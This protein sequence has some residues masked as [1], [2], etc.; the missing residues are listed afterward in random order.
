VAR[1]GTDAGI[2]PCIY[3]NVRVHR[4]GVSPS[5]NL[6]FESSLLTTGAKATV[7]SGSAKVAPAKLK[8]ILEE[9]EKEGFNHKSLPDFGSKLAAL[10]LNDSVAAGLEGTTGNHLVVVH[11]AEASRIPWETICL[12][13]KFPAL[14]GGM[15]RRYLATDLSVAK[16]LEQRRHDDWLDV[17]L[18]VDPTGDLRGARE[19]GERIGKLFTASQ[20]V[21]LT[22]VIGKEATRARLRAEFASGQYDILHYAGHA[23]FDP[24]QTAR[25]GII[26]SDGNLTGA[27]LVELGNLP[28]LVFFNACE[29]AR[30]RSQVKRESELVS[31][32]IT[33]RIERNAGL[34]EAFMRGGVANY[35]GTYW[36]VSDDAAKSFAGEFYSRVLDGETISSA[37]G[38]A[39]V[40]VDKI[41]SQDWADY[42]FYG[43]IDFTVKKSSKT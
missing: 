17:L 12:D 15:S 41:A 9:I 34:A 24:G 8:A 14:A 20:Q 5:S 1:R 40:E 38:K 28:S 33:E 31:R 10:V 3:L 25:S 2:P 11:D 42:I 13:K 35:I 27:E 21:H 7:L 37:L 22:V 19:E 36:P 18:V 29:S 4:D 6:V 16:W 32:N 23:Y 26:C 30:V 43:S 39:R